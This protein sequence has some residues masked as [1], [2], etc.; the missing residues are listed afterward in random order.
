MQGREHMVQLNTNTNLLKL[1]AIVSMLIDHIG[2]AIFPQYSWLRVVGRISFPLICYCLAVGSIYT[3]NMP[4]YLLRVAIM[5][6][7]SQPFYVLALNHITPAMRALDFLQNPV[8]AALKWYGLSMQY[9]NIMFELL[10][11][12]L[13]IWTIKTKKYI[14]TG[15]MAL[16]VWY[17]SPYLTTSYGV[18]GVVLMLLFYVLF[19]RPLTSLILVCGYMLWWGVEGRAYSIGSVRFGLQTFA[20]LALPAIYWPCRSRMKLNKWVFYIFYPL[21]LAVIYAW[22]IFK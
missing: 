21:H 3:H 8:L 22:N 16:V 9:A 15:V 14:L 1:I 17:A 11:G 20:V 10:L 18:R 12:L 19:D 7:V 2:V 6:L 13:M 4:R 5:G